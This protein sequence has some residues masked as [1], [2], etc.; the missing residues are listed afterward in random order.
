MATLRSGCALSDYCYVL[1]LKCGDIWL[2]CTVVKIHV[3]T[4]D[5]IKE[6][7]TISIYITLVV[8][9]EGFFSV[10]LKESMFVPFCDCTWDKR[11][12]DVVFWCF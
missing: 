2:F 12:L 4:S 5:K 8:S 1:R 7:K 9:M 6:L 3:F 11:V 10:I